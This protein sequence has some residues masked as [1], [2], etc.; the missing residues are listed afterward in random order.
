[1]P[2]SPRA[3]FRTAFGAEQDPAFAA[4]MVSVNRGRLRV[5]APLMA[6][7]HAAHVV[8]FA[9]LGAERA[10]LAPTTLLWRDGLVAA[11][12]AMVPLALF[13]TW[14]VWRSASE[15]LLRWVA[16]AAATLWLV[17]GAIC[18][19][20]DQLVV[21]NISA[22]QGYCLGI[23]VI[24]CLGRR[25]TLGA[26]ALAAS[27]MLAGLLFLQTRPEAFASNLPPYLTITLV[28]VALSWLLQDARR[29][30]FG[31]RRIIESQR[32]ELA[33]LNS[34]LEQRVRAQVAEILAHSKDADRLNA[35][36][37]RA[38]AQ[39]Q[40]QVRSRSAELSLALSRL[41]RG[42]AVDDTLAAGTVLGDR[43]VIEAPL[44]A[45]GMGVVYRGHDQVTN[46]LV[47]IKVIQAGG[48]RSQDA[49][50]RFLRE[51]G[52]AASVSHPAVVRMLHLDVSG[53]GLVFQ[54]QEL[55]EGET[56]STLLLRPWAAG[57]AARLG[58]AL[59]DA[60]AAAHAQGIAHL[61]VKPQ[62]VMLVPRAPGLKLLDFG[63]ARLFE[64]TAAGDDTKSVGRVLG[65]PAY[66]APEQA[67]GREHAGAPADLYATGVLLFRLLTG[68]VPFEGTTPR[69]T[70]QR[71]L[72]ET[73]PDVRRLATTVPEAL[74]LLIARCLEKSPAARPTARELYEK[75]RALADALGAPA[76]ESLRPAPL[77]ETVDLV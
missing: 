71:H 37:Q 75:L 9:A 70:L 33:T 57:D 45:G 68:A 22:Y 49:L 7:V 43:F 25:A 21:A 24:Y 3:L 28:G 4:E 12:A 41:A 73:A 40:A 77:A 31:Q 18:A 38:N 23:P 8:H 34:G 29:R 10:A 65:T 67:D 20:L 74:A 55:V 35:E 32:E 61:D 54:V 56:L 69:E 19:S 26:Y 30:E 39:L 51:A 6:V 47:A 15:A 48:S 52:A 16:P 5:F 59:C 13:G 53:E 76:L 46:Q 62:N 66:M 42:T 11:H 17:H 72:F 50:R 14:I 2:F 58:A 63:I 36:L 27:A 60:L 1:V 44:G 64:A